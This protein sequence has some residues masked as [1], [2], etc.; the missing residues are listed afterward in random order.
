MLVLALD[1]TTRAGSVAVARNGTVVVERAGDPSRTQAERLPEWLLAALADAGHTLADVDRLAVLS[2]PGGFTGLRVGLATMQGL[3][4]GLGRDVHV[5]STLEVLAW[6]AAQQAPAEGLVGAWMRGMRGEVFT[7]AYATMP[8][9]AGE[10]T[11]SGLTAVLSPIV[12]LPDAAA[13]RWRDAVQGAGGGAGPILVAG[14]AWDSSGTTLV[15]ALGDRPVVHVDV[16]LPASLLARLASAPAA[17]GVPP[18][19]VAPTYLRRPDAVIARE[20]D[21]A[22]VPGA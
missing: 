20:R 2:G 21:G 17:A 8:G 13:A 7:A 10:R 9:A 22:V 3:A 18:H 11:A 4:L 14:D 12:E 15:E 19:A 6:G 16:G 1:T 5:A